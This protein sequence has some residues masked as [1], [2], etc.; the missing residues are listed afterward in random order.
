MPK[1]G[2]KNALLEY[3]WARILKKL[4]RYFKS[5]PSNLSNLSKTRVKTKTHKFEIKCVTWVFL[6]QNLKV[7][8]CS[9]SAPLNMS[10]CKILRKN[11]NAQIL[12]QKCVIWIYLGYNL[13]TLL[14]YWNQH[15]QI[16]LTAKFFEKAKMPKFGIK[17]ALFRLFWARVWKKY[18]HILISTLEFINTKVLRKNKKA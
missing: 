11:K 18:C 6:G 3:L 9:K 5:A 14:S 4:L 17:N 1:C 7:L 13:K 2:T 12:Y 16:C 15:P 8:S 10:I